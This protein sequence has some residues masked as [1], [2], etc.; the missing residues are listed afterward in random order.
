MT[1]VFAFFFY[2]FSLSLDDGELAAVA[3]PAVG[4]LLPLI[5][6]GGILL[7]EEVWGGL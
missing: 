7:W 5:T 6:S 2:C 3:D 1:T 4:L